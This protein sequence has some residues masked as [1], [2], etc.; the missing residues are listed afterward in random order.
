MSCS[1]AGIKILEYEP[2]CIHLDCVKKLGIALITY[3]EKKVNFY[4]LSN[5][6]QE[7]SKRKRK[8]IL[9]KTVIS[10]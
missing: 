2:K 9:N 5:L 4:D 7:P 1:S 6:L 8:E 10:N 3:F